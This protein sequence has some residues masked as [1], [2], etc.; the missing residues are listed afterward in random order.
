MIDHWG[1]SLQITQETC[2]PVPHDALYRTKIASTHKNMY[3]FLNTIVARLH[4]LHSNDLLIEGCSNL[5]W[6]LQQISV[7]QATDWIEQQH[8]MD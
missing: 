3:T 7:C 6:V 2:V 5:E 1:Y 8:A 4:T